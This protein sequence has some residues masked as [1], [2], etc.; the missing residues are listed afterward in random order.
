MALINNT[1]VH[2]TSEQLQRGVTVTE[3]PV[4]E[5]LP[6]TDNVK[7]NAV[8]LSLKGE[9]VKVGSTKAKTIISSLA[10]LHQ[11]GKYVKFV[12]RNV[13][14]NALITEFET[15]HTNAIVGG[16]TFSMTLKEVRIAKSA[17][18][19]KGNKVTGKQ[20]QVSKSRSKKSS[21][22]YHTVKK[23]DCLWNIAKKYYGDGSQYKKI[24]NANKNIVKSDYT[25]YPGQKLLIP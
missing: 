24:Y 18:V 23:G 11:K 2:V 20:K 12:G 9:I 7:R 4:E 25:I 1:Y 15:E 3:H 13:M 22:K 16:C 19:S 14:N 8:V 21:K 6:I 17:Y 5:G 10:K